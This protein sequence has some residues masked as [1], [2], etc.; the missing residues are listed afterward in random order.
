MVRTWDCVKRKE[1]L[2]SA[3]SAHCFLER[4]LRA[5]AH[6]RM[7]CAQ[8]FCL[9]LHLALAGALSGAAVAR[10]TQEYAH[11]H[12]GAGLEGC[13]LMLGTAWLRPDT[14]RV[15]VSLLYLRALG[16]QAGAEA[17]FLTQ[18]RRQPDTA[19]KA[20]RRASQTTATR[21]S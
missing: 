14:A 11:R 5:L 21:P 7:P 10:R 3:S 13:I 12:R 4:R 16:V 8:S 17:M 15:L 9:L 19:L 20:P 1:A 18:T 2:R 6:L